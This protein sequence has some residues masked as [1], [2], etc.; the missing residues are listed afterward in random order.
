MTTGP[1]NPSRSSSRSSS[2]SSDEVQKPELDPS[3]LAVWIK[4]ESVVMKAVQQSFQL[5]QEKLLQPQ[6]LSLS[7]ALLEIDKRLDNIADI[8]LKL[9]TLSDTS[10][11]IK[12]AERAKEKD[13]IDKEIE[14]FE[15]EMESSIQSLIQQNPDLKINHDFFSDWKL[16]PWIEVYKRKTSLAYMKEQFLNRVFCRILFLEKISNQINRHKRE[17]VSHFIDDKT[18]ISDIIEN[19]SYSSLTIIPDLIPFYEKKVGNFS[20]EEIAKHLWLD[21]EALIS[22]FVQKVNEVAVYLCKQGF[23]LRG[24][25]ADGNCFCRAFLKSCATLSRIIPILDAQDNKISYL[26]GEI[27]NQYRSSEQAL[28]ARAEQIEQ[29][30]EWITASGEGDL[31]ARALEIPIRVV[32][33]NQAD[34]RCDINDM[35]TFSE[36]GRE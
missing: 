29:D 1:I 15:A 34:D 14:S 26:R 11:E 8:A 21:P 6:M 23:E 16:L 7:T 31:L 25:K 2:F 10:Q 30:K 22:D 35:L 17:I 36:K 19:P 18:R 4:N 5:R 33:V 28:L 32:S 12:T 20:E 9:S 13:L 24:V 27:A 3:E